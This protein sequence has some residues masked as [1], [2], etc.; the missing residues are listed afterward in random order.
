MVERSAKGPSMNQADSQTSRMV[1]LMEKLA[2]IEGYNLSALED[3]RF[4]RSNRP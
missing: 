4:L 3:I 2:P 1:Q